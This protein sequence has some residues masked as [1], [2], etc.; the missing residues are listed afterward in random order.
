MKPPRVAP[1]SRHA[2]ERARPGAM[3]AASPACGL[4]DQHIALRLET[5]EGVVCC[6]F[7]SALARAY[8]LQKEF[9]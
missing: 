6:A 5:G 9:L 7:S 4:G 1:Y 3:D 2:V 8:A